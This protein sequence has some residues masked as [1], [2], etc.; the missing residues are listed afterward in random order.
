MKTKIKEDITN[1][2]IG[3][4]YAIPQT[5]RNQMEAMVILHF[6]IPDAQAKE[7]VGLAIVR[8]LEIYRRQEKIK[9][10]ELN[11]IRGRL[12]ILLQMTPEYDEGK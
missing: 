6:D 5:S 2:V 8:M 9:Q 3:V 7:S 11:D 1:Y 10:R 4:L 12:D